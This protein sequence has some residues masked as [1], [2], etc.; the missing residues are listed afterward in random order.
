MQLSRHLPQSLVVLLFLAG[1]GLCLAQLTRTANTTL[2]LPSTPPG[3][4]SYMC[5]DA[6]TGFSAPIALATPPGE[7]GRLFVVERNNGIQVVDLNA[8]PPT[9]QQFLNISSILG[10]GETLATDGECGFLGL[11][12]HPNFAAN[13]T[14]FIFYSINSGGLR[15]QR[16][17]RLQASATNPN[18]AD[19]S[20]HAPL[21]TQLDN[22]SNH[23]GGDLHFGPDGYLYVSLGDEGGSNDTNN[24][25]RWIDRDFFCAILRLDVD[26]ANVG[27]PGGSVEPNSHASINLD[28]NN[29]A[30]YS[31]PPDNPFLPGAPGA[32]SNPIGNGAYQDGSAIDPAKIRTEFWAVGFRNPWRMSFDKPTGRLFVG[33]V[34]SSTLEEIDIVIRGGNYGWAYREGTIAGP[35]SNPPANPGSPRLDPIHEYPRTLG[36]SVT[37]GLVYRGSAL[38]GLYGSYI[39]ADYGSGRVFALTDTGNSTWS[40]QELMSTEART[41]A[42]GTDPRN[43]D[44]LLAN[45]GNGR[46]RRLVATQPGGSSLPVR[47]SDT[48]A[49][50]DL[51]SLAPHPGIVPFTP[52]LPF[53]SDHAI[54]T[55]W[56][57]IP[58]PA[59]TFGFF[60]DAPW[61]LPT[62]TIWIKHFEIEATRG[63]PATR[64]RLETRFLVKNDSGAYGITYRWRTDQ[65]DADLVP[66]SGQTETFTVMVDGIP[67]SQT[68]RYPSRSECMQCHTPQGGH[69]LGFNTRQL[70]TEHPY[71]TGTANQIAALRD[72]GYLAD[73]PAIL[74]TLPTLALPD[75]ETQSL[76]F[77]ARS[78]LHV[79]CAQCHQPGGTAPTNWD[80]RISTPLAGA[81]I[82][83]GALSS[84]GG[85][86]SAR[87]LVPGSTAHSMLLTRLQGTGS[88]QRMPPLGSNEPDNSTINLVS[89][90]IQEEP[91]S[92]QTFSDW[93]LSQFGSTSDPDARA[94]AD[95]DGD[96]RTNRLE[97]LARTDPNDPSSRW[98]YQF[99]IED[100][101]ILLAY[102]RNANRRH[103]IQTSTNLIDWS[104]WDI[105]ENKPHISG[106]N[107][108]VLIEA[109]LNPEDTRRFF[110]ILVEDTY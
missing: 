49:F 35:R 65:S 9:K 48:G 73:A 81:A 70:N 102:T 32:I 55:R 39:F 53:W 1:P 69:A 40:S 10:P 52:K 75:D 42:F 2:S 29:K 98:T 89:R 54:K 58:S 88:L 15:Y 105:P 110:R 86:A 24:N 108:P 46:I 80:A 3:T 104:D 94:D 36:Y 45:I 50:S 62:G 101:Q 5:Q 12:F 4:G 33:D 97:F 93:Q 22:A 79:N 27:Q 34:G 37:G 68:W 21:I 96:G 23:N 109:A 67:Q 72:A 78:A 25:S 84:D 82:I 64:R 106:S 61:S 57:S 83:N 26:R 99:G 30:R 31:I 6:Y 103:T 8:V 20:T 13:R 7:T 95:P 90:W 43:G 28:D 18:A 92:F 66:D 85:N 17:A 107:M 11:A 38:P 71:D 91:A 87:V 56:F 47:L 44:V 63:N 16:I 77:R 76:E 59:P 41:V 74:H 60:R 19:T 14:F 100:G 51:G